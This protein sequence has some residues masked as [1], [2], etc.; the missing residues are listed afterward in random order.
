MN[1]LRLPL[2]KQKGI[3]KFQIIQY[4][5][6]CEAI[7]DI[8]ITRY[9]RDDAKEAFSTTEFVKYPN[10]IAADTRITCGNTPLVLCKIKK[11]REI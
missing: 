11:K 6:I 9:F 2:A 4:A 5:S 10:A 3:V 1:A 7:L 8:A